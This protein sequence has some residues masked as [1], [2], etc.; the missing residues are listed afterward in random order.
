MDKNGYPRGTPEEDAK[1]LQ[2]WWMEEMQACQITGSVVVEHS[3]TA[4]GGAVPSAPAAGFMNWL[5]TDR[6]RSPSVH[7]Y[8]AAIPGAPW[9]ISTSIASTSDGMVM[10]V[11]LRAQIRRPLGQVTF[12][13]SVGW[14]G[15]KLDLDGSD[16]SRFAGQRALM[17]KIKANLTRR[18]D[19]PLFG[20]HAKKKFIAL[21]QASLAIHPLEGGSEVVLRITP[22]D[23]AAFVGRKYRLGLDKAI[24]ILRALEA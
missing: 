23:E 12:R 21:D 8:S 17:K 9:P 16:A 5:D 6:I 4:P 7:F 24:E 11:V 18:Y 3:P 10:E 20:F 22:R 13:K 1:K 14:F 19:P 2:T 15:D